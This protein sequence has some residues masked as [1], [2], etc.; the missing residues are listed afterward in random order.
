MRLNFLLLT[1][2]FV[3]FILISGCTEG[4]F[5]PQV[6]LEIDKDNITLDDNTIS[7]DF[8]TVTVER[9]DKE[10]IGTVFVLKFPG[11]L[12]SV[13]PT[14]S[15]GEKIDEMHTKTLKG[16]NSKDTLQFKIFGSK[17]QATEAS[18]E[19]NMELWWN[20]TKLEEKDIKITVK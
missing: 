20:N 14:N 15:D 8:I 1:I 17:G 5:K 11:N 13:Y 7:T 18:Y 10:D 3:G 12:T 9:L 4:P 16:Q 2:L 19:L 6:K